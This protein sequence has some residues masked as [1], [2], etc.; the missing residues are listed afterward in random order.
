M[1]FARALSV[2]GEAGVKNLPRLEA[3]IEASVARYRIDDGDE[4]LRELGPKLI[5]APQ[6]TTMREQ[7]LERLESAAE[8]RLPPSTAASPAFLLAFERALAETGVTFSPE[9][10][11]DELRALRLALPDASPERLVALLTRIVPRPAPRGR[12]RPHFKNASAILCDRLFSALIRSGMPVQIYNLNGAT[13]YRSAAYRFV[14]TVYT[15]TGIPLLG[16]PS[17]RRAAK[18]AI[19]ENHARLVSDEDATLLREGK[20]PERRM[21]AL[22][23][24]IRSR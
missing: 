15:E 20:L 18:K 23:E 11:E 2:A 12:G 24:R 8:A 6:D 21:A 9:P 1:R 16:E 17:L 4:A 7:L 5:A 14:Q 3:E 10:S 19:R 13:L 22:F